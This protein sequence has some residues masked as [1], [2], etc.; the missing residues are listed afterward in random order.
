MLMFTSE[1]DVA[2]VIIHAFADEQIY[3]VR[4]GTQRGNRASIGDVGEGD[5]STRLPKHL[6]RGIDLPIIFER[7][8]V[9]QTRPHLY[10]QTECF[11][12]F[13]LKF[14]AAR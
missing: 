12:L 5:A 8:A 3:F 11:C 1:R 2:G 14:R 13:D 9:L 6:F 7:L 4:E 10:R